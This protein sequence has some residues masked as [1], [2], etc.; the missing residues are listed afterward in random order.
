MHMGEVT[1]TLSIY[2][3]SR[4]E[5]IDI[6]VDCEYEIN[7]NGIGPY[8]F[9]GQVG[10][11]KGIDYVEI[12][13]TEWDKTGFTPE[14]VVLIEKKIDKEVVQWENEIEV[15]DYCPPDREDED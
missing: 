13:D 14:E 10:N 7:N 8:E 12:I 6:D 4:G 3:D 2:L 15:N 5:D 11:D 9:W 1:K